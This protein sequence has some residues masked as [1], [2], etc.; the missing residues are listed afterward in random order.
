MNNNAWFKK[1]KPLLS[2]QSMG[3]GASGTLMQGASDKA[4]IDKVF[5]TYVYT[6]D[7][8][9]NRDI[10]NNIDLSSNG[11][12][13]WTK[14]RD[15]GLDYHIFNTDSG[16][17]KY[18]V[19][20][21]SAAESTIGGGDS[22]YNNT[23]KS[24]NEDGFSLGSSNIVNS[25]SNNYVSWTFRKQEKFFD[26]VTYTGNGSARTI[27]HNLGSTPGMIMVKRLDTGDSWFTYHRSLGGTQRIYLNASSAAVTSSTAWNDTDPT[28]SVFSVGTDS[29]VNANGGTY[30][31]YLFA[32][33]NSDGPFGEDSDKDAISCGTYTGNGS[34]TGPTINLG[35]EPQW[36]IIKRTNSTEHWALFDA[37]RGIT[38]DNDARLEASDAGT[39][40]TGFDW[41]QL[42]SKGFQLKKDDAGVNGS[43]STYVYMAIR[44]A[45][46]VV[47]KPAEAGTD[48]FAMDVGNSSATGPAF[49]ANFAVDFALN[50]EFAGTDNWA[51]TTRLTGR[52]PVYTNSTDSEQSAHAYYY[53]DFNN[54]W[55]ISM[56]SNYQSW[57]W[58]R[59]K[60]FD[61]LT[62]TTTGSG[63][64]FIYH[65]CMGQTPEMMWMKRRDSNP[66]EGW[67]VYH[68]DLNGGTTSYNWYLNLNTTAKEAESG[69]NMWGLSN[70]PDEDTVVILDTYFGGAG[71]YLLLLFASVD[72]IS[73]VGSY[74][75]NGNTGQTI[76]TGF[77]PRFLI[78]KS[79]T[80][81][82][83]R[84]WYVFDTTRGWASGDDK[85]L[86]INETA[87]QFDYNVGQPTSTGFTLNDGTI[88]YNGDGEKYIYYAH[89]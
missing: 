29:G 24:F 30:I 85:W 28:S 71:D 74:T 3:G 21:T 6:G 17:N 31:A 73:K 72:G 7:D 70:P 52:K 5:S 1:E 32:H 25:S 60:G 49:D 15:N 87:A 69:G 19:T 65:T 62:P 80:S 51:T 47:G 34:S 11:G 36:V 78:I 89:A 41:I 35:W 50:R 64:T 79:I 23:L 58:K 33:N 14:S 40:N 66:T 9:A 55:A 37:M 63:Y 57:M 18:M 8:S 44:M 42:T 88:S 48:V 2:L 38:A 4:Y 43:G 67:R 83:L 76:T 39:E 81:S 12:L 10:T 54:G 20:N 82:T 75:G 56:P 53:D 45:D 27:D 16:L 77:Q 84:S 86:E 59:G 68:K 61:V 13:V 22:N 46:G 26:M